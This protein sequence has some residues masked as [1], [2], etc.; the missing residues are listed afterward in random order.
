M[1]SFK[2]YLSDYGYSQVKKVDSVR[3]FIV[4]NDA[5]FNYAVASTKQQIRYIN[6]LYPFLYAL[7]GII[8]V[9]VSYLLVISRKTEFAIMRGLGGTRIRTFFSFFLEQG[10]LCV[11]GS[12]IGLAGWWIIKGTPDDLHLLLTGGFLICYFAG[13]S[14]SILIMN[15]THVLTILLDRD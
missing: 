6:L 8:A 12:F 9:V 13:C 3:E 7:V 15:H 5:A 10:T 11:L 2:D 14:L 4:L 1:G